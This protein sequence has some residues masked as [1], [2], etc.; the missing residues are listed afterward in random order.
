M[1]FQN[2]LFLE[3]KSFIFPQL[4]YHY[5]IGNQK[6]SCCNL[7]MVKNIYMCTHIDTYIKMQF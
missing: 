5:K 7:H 6:I 4:M 3:Y 1:F 2:K